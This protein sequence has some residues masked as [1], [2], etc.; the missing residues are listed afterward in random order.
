M[1][2]LSKFAAAAL[3]AVTT[4]AAPTGALA[5]ANDL[6]AHANLWETVQSVGVSTLINHPICYQDGEDFDG[7]YASGD[8]VLIVCQDNATGQEVV[9]FTDNDLDTIRHEAIHLIQDCLDGRADNSLVHIIPDSRKRFNEAV[10]AL[11]LDTVQRIIAAYSQQG[12]DLHVI[13]LELEAFA[14]ANNSSA[15]DI[16]TIVVRVCTPRP[17]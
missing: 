5:G 6:A 2:V 11:G 7:F 12:A 9:N 13:N 14:F 1:S 8:E 15:E 3:A 4:F 10:A 17:Q 16:A